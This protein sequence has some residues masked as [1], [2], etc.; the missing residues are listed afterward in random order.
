VIPQLRR[1]LPQLC[2][3]PNGFLTPNILSRFNRTHGKDIR[4]G[5][6]KQ[7]GWRTSLLLQHQSF[8]TTPFCMIFFQIMKT[9]VYHN[10]KVIIYVSQWNVFLSTPFWF[11]KK[12]HTHFLLSFL[13]CPVLLGVFDVHHKHSEAWGGR[14]KKSF[15]KLN[16][17][18]L[19]FLSYF[20]LGKMPT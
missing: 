2:T 10:I 12:L 5:A 3:H 17:F 19:R 18:L 13:K 11:S 1:S 9:K 20:H 14:T 16:Y 15:K 7:S 8:S 4:E 6:D